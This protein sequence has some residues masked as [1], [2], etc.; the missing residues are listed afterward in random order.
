MVPYSFICD[1]AT[2]AK[3]VRRLLCE[4]RVEV[5]SPTPLLYILRVLFKF[6]YGPYRLL[7]CPL[8]GLTDGVIRRECG[9]ILNIE[10]ALSTFMVEGLCTYSGIPFGI[11]ETLRE[12]VLADVQMIN[13]GEGHE[14]IHSVLDWVSR[15]RVRALQDL[16]VC[17][18]MEFTKVWVSTAHE[19]WKEHEKTWEWIQ[20]TREEN[21]IGCVPAI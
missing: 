4:D 1:A 11:G 6:Q 20:R 3:V 21:D 17:Q 2:E 15:V 12:R 9:F 8:Y 5:V 7:T 18:A 19:Q 16:A 13:R 10:R 14:V